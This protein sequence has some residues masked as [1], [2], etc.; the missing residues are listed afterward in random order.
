VIL[1]VFKME[2]SS[3]LNIEFI[4]LYEEHSVLWDPKHSNNLSF[5]D[6]IHHL[7]VRYLRFLFSS[8]NLAQD[9]TTTAA[10]GTATSVSFIFYY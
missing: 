8:T 5:R 7:L 4:N 2:Q 9:N 1:Q 10:A 6:N 3:E